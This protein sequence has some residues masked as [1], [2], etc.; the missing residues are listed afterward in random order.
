MLH[1]EAEFLL[2]PFDFFHLGER[3]DVGRKK[4]ST[5]AGFEPAIF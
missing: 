4:E 1:S 2:L 5:T 3:E